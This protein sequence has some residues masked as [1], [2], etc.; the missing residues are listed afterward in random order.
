MNQTRNVFRKTV[1]GAVAIAM[2]F[3]LSACGKLSPKQVMEKAQTSVNEVSSMSYDL[4]MKI[5]LSVGS[6]SLTMNT[7]MSTEYIVDPLQMKMD[8]T[9]DFGELGEATAEEYAAEE[10][11]RLMMYTGMDFGD[12]DVDWIK[13]ELPDMNGLM[14]YDAKASMD[15]YISSAESFTESGTETISGVNTVRYDG[16]I[17]GDAM[18]KVLNSSGMLEKFASLGLEEENVSAMLTDL[19]DLPIS[20]WIATDGYIPMQYEMDMTDIMQSMLAKSFDNTGDGAI[21]VDTVFVSI[22][23]KDVNSVAEILIPDEALNAELVS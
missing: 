1:C 6:E 18:E 20:I 10:D 19:G 2:C 4:T 9:M 3:A 22:T 15:L 13:Q 8:M 12:G 16:V 11:G 14:Q 21:S 23:V 7:T 17:K 5:K